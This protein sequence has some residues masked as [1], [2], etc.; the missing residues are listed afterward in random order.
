MTVHQMLYLSSILGWSPT[1]EQ[2][3]DNPPETKHTTGQQIEN[4]KGLTLLNAHE[5][6][7]EDTT[8]PQEY[9]V[10]GI[11]GPV[12]SLQRRRYEV[13]WCGYGPGDITLDQPHHIPTH[14]LLCDTGIDQY[15]NTD[16]QGIIK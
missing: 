4:W 16:G 11:M 3:T 7:E 15:V 6:T 10:S 2:V 8:V 12:D 5:A 14:T 13:R 9:V 1:C